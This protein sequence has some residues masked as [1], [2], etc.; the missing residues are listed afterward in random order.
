MR[1]AAA[2]L[3]LLLAG[4]AGRAEL[5]VPEGVAANDPRIGPCRR[6]AAAAPEL[7]A[8]GGRQPAIGFGDAYARWREDLTAAERN[9]F[10]ACLVRE[11]AMAQL[12]S[13]VEPVRSP[14]FGSD[15]RTLPAPTRALPQA[16]RPIPSGY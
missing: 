15:D 6:E 9:G 11:G 8:I 16:P 5:P 13:G 1:R 7:R 12:P 14:T 10:I 2:L 3:L 4:C